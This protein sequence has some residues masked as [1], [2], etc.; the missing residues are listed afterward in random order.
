MLDYIHK[1][2]DLRK[3]RIVVQELVFFHVVATWSADMQHRAVVGVEQ[4]KTV[5]SR[6]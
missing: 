5:F 1:L 2:R 4:P 3:E 6:E